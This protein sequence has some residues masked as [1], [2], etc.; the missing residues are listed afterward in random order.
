MHPRTALIPLALALAWTFAATPVAAQSELPRKKSRVTEATE[1]S[2]TP[3]AKKK[4]RKHASAIE[5]EIPVAPLDDPPPTASRRK[6]KAAPASELP[7]PRKERVTSTDDEETPPAPAPR[8]SGVRADP[9]DE[10]AP[11]PRPT[12][13]PPRKSRSDDDED[14]GSRRSGKDDD[15]EL[16]DEA[17]HGAVKRSSRTAEEDLADADAEDESMAAA[18]EPGHAL[19]FT[20]LL[21]VAFV[22]NPIPAV[23]TRFNLGCSFA[24]GAGRYIF[25][26]EWEFLH[27]NFIV[28][29]TWTYAFRTSTGT[30]SVRVASD[31][32][33]LSLAI[34]FGYPIPI[35][36]ATSASHLLLYGKIG[37]AM[38]ISS[39]QYDVQGSA[40]SFVGVKG[41]VVY[42][43][44][45]RTNIY[46]DSTVGLAV[47]LEVL[48]YR[49]GY[50]NDAQINAGMGVAF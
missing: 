26:P 36:G 29:V 49:R 41:G 21:G 15:A 11:R 10:P 9:A 19:S 16:R 6:G 48:G 43:V 18:D 27:N 8:S 2:E 13:P 1:E 34:A 30:D 44:G 25:D 3:V 42:G 17:D 28:D 35:E 37:P 33:T 31:H 4:K 5:D 40:V 24:W 45:A 22:D 50:L 14:T 38:T 47:Q 39:V 20:A 32:N 12:E 23:D 46:L 7:P